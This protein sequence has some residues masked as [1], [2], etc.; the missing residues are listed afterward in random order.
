M[1]NANNLIPDMPAHDIA[2]IYDYIQTVPPFVIDESLDLYALLK[3]LITYCNEL[4][5]RNNEL[6]VI[7]QNLVNFLNTKLQEHQTFITNFI[8]NLTNEWNQY[9]QTLD[10]KY[11]DFVAETNQKLTEYQTA[12]ENAF[13]NDMAQIR[14]ENESKYQELV[15]TL[16][17]EIQSL[18]STVDTM[19]STINSDINSFE[20]QINTT[21]NTYHTEFLNY[22]N[23]IINDLTTYQQENR[24]AVNQLSI[25]VNNRINEIPQQI[26][27]AKSD[28]NLAPAV[29]KAFETYDLTEIFDNIYGTIINL[30]SMSTGTLEQ[31]PNPTP[32][33]NYNPDTYVL[34]NLVT[35]ESVPLNSNSIY[36]YQGYVYIPVLGFGLVRQSSINGIKKLGVSLDNECII[37]GTDTQILYFINTRTNAITTFNNPI[38]YIGD[39][40]QGLYLCIL[41]NANNRIFLFQLI[42]NVKWFIAYNYIENTTQQI[43]NMG[44]SNICLGVN[45]IPNYVIGYHNY[46]SNIFAIFYDL[47][48]NEPN[49]E[50]SAY[51][52]LYQ[53]PYLTFGIIPVNNDNYDYTFIGIESYDVK[54]RNYNSKNNWQNVNSSSEII[55]RNSAEIPISVSCF[56]YINNE[57]NAIY[58]MSESPMV[59]KLWKYNST[60]CRTFNYTGSPLLGCKIFDINEKIIS[61]K[62]NKI[63][64][65]TTGENNSYLTI[66][67]DSEINLAI[68][69]T[70]NSI[71]FKNNY[72]L[73]SSTP[74][75][76][77]IAGN[78]SKLDEINYQRKD[79]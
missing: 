46:E 10:K 76:L 57:F 3:K 6:Q 55:D 31:I 77:S 70:L 12:I 40:K 29:Q 63:I 79:S 28:V 51:I 69:G 9:Q 7:T 22:Q 73:T 59:Y 19:Q 15:T 64:N 48:T 11:N 67:L 32:I 62:D 8:T 75:E 1:T 61:Y 13:N 39:D 21:I 43:I 58:Y 30:Y 2:F 66:T 38:N 72:Y 47:T 71:A 16:T 37:Y 5:E 54:Y 74:D 25:Q 53:A 65:V 34:T 20:S 36:L 44:D 14:N 35:L 23:D 52:T 50:I 49:F 24:E 4:G 68:N 42:N 26:E 45:F 60:K 56:G 17:N 27:D 78:V 33:Y 18:Q 41:D